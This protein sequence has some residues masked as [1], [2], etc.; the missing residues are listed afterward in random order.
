MVPVFQPFPM[1]GTRRAQAWRYHPAYRRPRHVHD[2]SE[3]NLVLAGTGAMSLG[4]LRI[5]LHP[6]LLLWLPP[7]V[8]H[9][10]ERAS[11]DFDLVVVG[12][13]AELLEAV[14]REHG[15]LPCFSREV[16]RLDRDPRALGE[17]L[18]SMAD[19]N[20]ERAVEQNLVGSLLALTGGVRMQ[21]VG[22]RAAG[23]LSS[24]RTLGRD[25]LARRLAINRGDLSRRFQREHGISIVEYK[26]RLRL[27][28]F[29]RESRE[30]PQNL[31]R[32]ALVAGFGSYSQCHRVFRDAFG[33]GPRDYLAAGGA[34]PD[35]FE[36]WS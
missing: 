21:G 9:C 20:D 26:N 18:L 13:D 2:E 31:M 23:M 5:E 34:D 16:E 11:S 30:R 6:G 32:A 35:R 24:E 10:L 25:E 15:R 27:M 28:T 12:F 8:D 19:G 33:V 4:S 36:P 22:E 1:L 29:L 3:F 17:S 7:G 14:R